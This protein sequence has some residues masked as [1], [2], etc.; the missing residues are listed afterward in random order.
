[1]KKSDELG[2]AYVA[3]YYKAHEGENTLSSFEFESY[4]G[5]YYYFKHGEE[6]VKYRRKQVI[7][8]KNNLD[9]WHGNKS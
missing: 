2:N 1:M 9:N 7:I 5:G 3:S 8:N 6:T 4:H